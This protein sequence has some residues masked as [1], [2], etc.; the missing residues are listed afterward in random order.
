MENNMDLVVKPTK[1]GNLT[2]YSLNN[3]L[4]PTEGVNNSIVGGLSLPLG[5]YRYYSLSAN[6]TGYT[7]ISDNT[8]LKLTGNFNLAK[9]YSNKELPFYKRYF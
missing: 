1:Y 9:G 7:P 8:T 3:Y 5:D 6:H 2:Y 4:Y